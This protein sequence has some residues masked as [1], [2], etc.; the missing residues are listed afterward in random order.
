H[1]MNRLGQ[2]VTLSDGG[3]DTLHLPSAD[4]GGTVS[5]RFDIGY[6]FGENAGAVLVSYRF[7]TIEG[8]VQYIDSVDGLPTGSLNSRL[9]IQTIDFD[10]A[11]RDFQ[12]GSHW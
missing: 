1:V 9:D 10:Y 11:T 6:R 3:T 2:T 12:L 8:C 5:P 7:L 4:L